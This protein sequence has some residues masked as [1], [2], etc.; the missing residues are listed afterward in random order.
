MQKEP[1]PAATG[2]GGRSSR[3][4]FL[5][6]IGGVT[7]ALGASVAGL[8]PLAANASPSPAAPTSSRANPYPPLP[9]HR[10][11]S[12]MLDQLTQE[13]FAQHLNTQ[14]RVHYQTETGDTATVDLKLVEAKYT[15][16]HA[17]EQGLENFALLFHGSNAVPLTQS[18]YA[19]EHEQLGRMDLFIVPVGADAD[20]RYYECIF[21]R[22]ARG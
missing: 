20:N 16:H 9:V 18:T 5:G 21:N 22:L 14:F 17:P 19:F 10:G 2:S 6:R 13:S 3:R 7:A 8:S 1:L 12:S 11:E 15:R 4:A